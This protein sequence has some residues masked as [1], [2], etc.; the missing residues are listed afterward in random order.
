VKNQRPDSLDQAMPLKPGQ[1]AAKG[2]FSRLRAHEAA[3]LRRFDFAVFLQRLVR[4]T[5][6][7]AY[8]AGSEIHQR[9]QTQ[10]QANGQ[11]GQADGSDKL[12]AGD[13][14]AGAHDCTQQKKLRR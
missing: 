7:L 14:D 8:G 6:M 1:R 9:T 2:F 10:V 13:V 11:I 12:I 4:D 3:A 5:A